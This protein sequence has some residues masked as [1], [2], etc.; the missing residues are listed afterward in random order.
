MIKK[1]QIGDR[2][3]TTGSLIY[4]PSTGARILKSKPNR[5][6][7]A[8]ILEEWES[9][10]E[11]VVKNPTFRGDTTGSFFELYNNA[12]YQ[13][14]DIYAFPAFTEGTDAVYLVWYTIW[15]K[16]F[17]IT[18][19]NESKIVGLSVVTE[20]QQH[21]KIL[22]YPSRLNWNYGLMM[23]VNPK[24]QGIGF[25]IVTLSDEEYAESAYSFGVSNFTDHGAHTLYMCRY[26]DATIGQDTNAGNFNQPVNR[27]SYLSNA[28]F[29]LTTITPPVGVALKTDTEPTSGTGGSDGTFD[30]FGDDV[31]YPELPTNSAVDT[32]LLTV[33][34][35]SIA[36]LKTISTWLWSMDDSIFDQLKKIYSNVMDYIVSMQFL[37]IVSNNTSTTDVYFGNTDTEI[38]SKKVNSQYIATPEVTISIDEYYGSFIDYSPT[39]I[40]LY[41]PFIGFRELSSQDVMSGMIGV[42]YHID[43]ITGDCVAFVKV[44]SRTTKSVLYTYNGNCS[45]QAP[46]S[47]RDFAQIFS[48]SVNAVASIGTVA[49]GNPT[50]LLSAGT[51][52]VDLMQAQNSINRGGAISGNAGFLTEYQPYLIFARPSAA[53][54]DNYAHF[55]GKPSNIT[56]KLSTLSGFTSIKEMVVNGFASAT[57]EEK[58]EVINLLKGGVYL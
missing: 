18:Y 55:Y 52:L 3:F 37:P 32:G 57:E 24:E 54:P 38:L 46:L 42:K 58:N 35:P 31:D 10:S 50:G 51:A 30:P 34:E 56:R 6:L 48:A 47:G 41:L 22:L 8:T 19:P 23:G 20:N 45:S 27:R 28:N 4:N 1:V 21:E 43:I 33:Y 40:M 15:G 2:E 39:K 29:N 49:T 16:E 14:S 53:Y 9:Y 13:H 36:E 17:P 11:Y 7:G 44:Y 26:E 25:Y 12:G 5:Y